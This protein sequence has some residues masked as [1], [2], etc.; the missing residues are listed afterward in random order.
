LF[1]GA[2]LSSNIILDP[3]RLRR[4]VEIIGNQGRFF[5][6]VE[7]IPSSTGADDRGVPSHNQVTWMGLASKGRTCLIPMGHPIGTKVIGETRIPKV[8]KDGKTRNYRH[9]VYEKPPEQMDRSTVFGILNPL[10]ADPDIEQG[11]HGA[12]FDAAS[13]AKYR[14]GL[15]PSGPVRCTILMRWLTDENRMRYGL[16][17]ITKDV[18]RF[19]YDDE[20]VGREV[21][22]YPLAKVAHYLHCD[23]RYGY[24]EMDN[25]RPVILDSGLGDL[26]EMETEL[27]SVLSE[28]RTHGTL[29]DTDRLEE[30]RSELF[31]LVQQRE[32]NVYTAVGRKINLNS[33]PQKQALLFKSQ[34]EGGLGLIPWKMTKGGKEKKKL[35]PDV[36][37]DHT[38]YST[39]DEAL[40]S[41]AGHPV[42]D[43]L[44]EYQETSKV[45]GTYVIGYLGD[46]TKKDKPTRIFDRRIYPDFVQYGAATGR[47]SCRDPNLQNVPAARTELGKMVRSLFIADDGWDLVVA[48]YGQVELVILAHFAGEGALF[49]GFMDGIDPHTMTAA[50]ILG[51]SPLDVTKIERQRFGKT[52]NFAVVY[53]AG[54]AKVAAMAEMEVTYEDIQ[55]RTADIKS[56]ARWMLGKGII[57]QAQYKVRI[58]DQ[59]IHD[60]ILRQKGKE[61]LDLYDQQFPEVGEL[62]KK[63]LAEAR[64][65]PEYG[66]PTLMGRLRRLPDLAISRNDPFR[67]GFLAYAERQA[68]NS[69]IQG[70]SADITKAA[71]VDFWHRKE[72]DWRLLLSVHD[73][74]VITS[75]EARTQ[76]AR[77]CLIESMTGP[78][79]Q[80][81]LTVPLKV[82]VAV[83]KNWAE[84]KD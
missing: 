40:E 61:L 69:K 59:G 23:V 36:V 80:D 78:H 73:E 6:D 84:A 38:F 25:L 46:K 55:E 13:V 10:F 17:Y 83:V 30:L 63:V 66:V 62:R 41:F 32:R 27:T 45:Y 70:S 15:I 77:A 81:L 31:T 48:D 67:K 12:T 68:F 18:Y 5:Y 49:Q 79:L 3:D 54:P 2:L 64:R 52:M 19:Q 20:N 47:F 60:E 58:S 4:E 34:E 8:G 35:N 29:I 14:F 82:D 1:G 22:K 39:D 24:L 72:P 76:D 37:P 50:M 16:K 57:D 7:T 53:G 33:A 11:A 21:E 65:H 43:A 9:P 71:M 28:M 51:K 75:P 74:L 42:V 44:L 26:W 56:K